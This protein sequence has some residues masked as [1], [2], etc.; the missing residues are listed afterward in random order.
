LSDTKAELDSVSCD[1]ERRPGSRRDVDAFGLGDSDTLGLWARDSLGD[2][3]G[4]LG[5]GNNWSSSSSSI[6]ENDGFG[7]GGGYSRLL[8][9]GD[10]PPRSRSVLSLCIRSCNATATSSALK[11]I[12]RLLL[13]TSSTVIENMPEANPGPRSGDKG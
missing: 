6:G 8:S 3:R 4:G 7:G 11:P 1:D 10:E 12:K 13:S 9:D 2:R 5:N